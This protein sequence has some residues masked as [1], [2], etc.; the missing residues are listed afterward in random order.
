[1][2]KFDGD[3]YGAQIEGLICGFIREMKS[4]KSLGE[5]W[6]F[7]EIILPNN[8][9]VQLSCVNSIDRLK[10]EAT[11]FNIFSIIFI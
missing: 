3:F 6:N 10:I 2:H 7:R 1:M 11:Y 5:I 4:F 9:V 8:I